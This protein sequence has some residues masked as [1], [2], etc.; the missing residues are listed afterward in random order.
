MSTINIDNTDSEEAPNARAP[1]LEETLPLNQTTAVDQRVNVNEAEGEENLPFPDFVP[2]VFYC[3]NQ[4]SFPRYQCL[5]LIMWPWFERLTLLMILLNCITLGMYEPCC[6]SSIETTKS[7]QSCQRSKSIW[8]ERIDHF[9]FI[10]FTVEMSIRMVAMGIF[11][12]KTYLAE[13]WNRL[14]CFIVLSG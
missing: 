14:D 8:L 4:R 12:K 2:R 10:Y 13:S 5:R 6:S 11:G 3:L 9:I 7:A 1:A